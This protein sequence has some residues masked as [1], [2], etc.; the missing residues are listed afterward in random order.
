MKG[1][2]SQCQV[3][4][5]SLPQIT[6]AQIFAIMPT[7]IFVQGLVL[8]LIWW[9]SKWLP[10]EWCRCVKDTGFEWV[11]SQIKFRDQLECVLLLVHGCPQHS[12]TSNSKEYLKD[13]CMIL[14][15][16]RQTS[17]ISRT[18]VGDQVV[19]HSDV[20]GA[21]PVGAAPTTSLFST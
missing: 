1:I 13:K 7:G 18:L 10:C 4:V 14:N 17:N 9:Q 11:G 20:F 3:Y 8:W 15:E 21:S 5:L 2:I 12:C 6:S 16:Y 19:D